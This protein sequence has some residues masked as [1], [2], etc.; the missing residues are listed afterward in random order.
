MHTAP[1]ADRS[2]LAR[3]PER[4]SVRSLEPRVL[5]TDAIEAPIEELAFGIII[6][7]LFARLD[8]P[9]HFGAFFRRG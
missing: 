2:S 9:G 8:D 1:E 6:G 3:H 7:I 5:S 4:E